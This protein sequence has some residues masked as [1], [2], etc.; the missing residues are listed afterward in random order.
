MKNY[1]ESPYWGLF[2]IL[3]CYLI[4]GFFPLYWIP[5]LEHPP[6]QLLAHRILWGAV[7]ALLAVAA[8]GK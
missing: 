6:A 8:L 2:S 5:L 3:V 4:W 7:F 1:S